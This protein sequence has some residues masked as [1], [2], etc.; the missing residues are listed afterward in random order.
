MENKIIN[1]KEFKIMYLSNIDKIKNKINKDILDDNDYLEYY[2]LEKDNLSEIEKLRVESENTSIFLKKIT[3]IQ[4]YSKKEIFNNL[5]NCLY[6]KKA[7]IFSCGY[8][9]TEHS[10]KFYKI[11]NDNEYLK[12]CWKSSCNSVKNV[13]ILGTP[14][15]F[16]DI[17]SFFQKNNSFKILIDIDKNVYENENKHNLNLLINRDENGDCVFKN[18]NIY[19]NSTLPEIYSFIIFI[20][21]LGIKEF[22]LF[23]FYIDTKWIDIRNYNYYDDIISEFGHYYDIKNTRM[24]EVG[25]FIEQ[26][27]SSRLHNFINDSVY[28]VSQIGC[29][30][31]NIPRID[32]ECIFKKNKTIIKSKYYYEDFI[33]QFDNY[34]DI[35]FYKKRHN[36]NY[37]FKEEVMYHYLKNIVL[38]HKINPDDN[39]EEIYLNN[40]ILQLTTLIPYILKYGRMYN[41]INKYTFYLEFFAHYVLIFNN[42]LNLCFYKDFKKISTEQFWDNLLVKNNLVIKNIDIIF[43]NLTDYPNIFLNNNKYFKLLY[44]IFILKNIPDDFNVIIYKELNDDLQHKSDIEAIYHYNDNGYKQNR[45]YKN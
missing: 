37:K 25:S 35:N 36:L 21:F 3:N 18:D 45:S 11:E 33:Y 6:N 32:F 16:D 17:F 1:I 41:K 7:C 10:D 40:M 31:N 26:I 2:K 9:L 13:D 42:S 14:G 43:N 8:N 15:Y 34:F 12:C 24:K 28:N 44:K 4:N 39:K 29:L 19:I 30:S 20:K 23:G 38:L 5:K 22:Y 27:M